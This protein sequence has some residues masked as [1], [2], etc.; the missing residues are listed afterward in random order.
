LPS[1]TVPVG[2]FDIIAL[3]PI[4]GPCVQMRVEGSLVPISMAH[5]A[6]DEG[7]PLAIKPSVSIIAL[8]WVCFPR[9]IG[10]VVFRK[11]KESSNQC[12]RRGARPTDEDCVR[13][14]SSKPRAV[15]HRKASL[16]M[17]LVVK[18]YESGLSPLHARLAQVAG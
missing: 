8:P 2:L 9:S 6:G 7:V 3:V 1:L 11:E 13:P 5:S 15:T 12:A 14:T 17:G 18:T 10:T 16:F 4:G